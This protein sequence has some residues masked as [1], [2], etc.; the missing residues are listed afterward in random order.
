MRGCY[1]VIAFHLYKIQKWLS[2]KQFQVGEHLNVVCINYFF[3][4]VK[5]DQSFVSV[6][7]ALPDHEI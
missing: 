3:A 6:A 7:K 5:Y 4:L 1:I 2:F